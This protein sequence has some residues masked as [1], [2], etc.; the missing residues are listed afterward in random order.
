VVGCS[1]GSVFG[2]NG[3]V[4]DRFDE[5]GD[6]SIS[7]GELN[8]AIRAWARGSISTTELQTVIRAWATG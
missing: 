4:V 1:D 3:S 8:A 6:G 7:T 5:D 2:V